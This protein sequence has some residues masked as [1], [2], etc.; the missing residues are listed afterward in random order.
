MLMFLVIGAI[1]LIMLLV[2]GHGDHDGAVDHDVSVGHD[3][4]VGGHD[5]G[6]AGSFPPILS[7]FNIS[8]FMM[9]FGAVGAGMRYFNLSAP[10]SALGG[11]GGGIVLGGIAFYCLGLFYRQQADSTMTTARIVGSVGTVTVP[12]PPNGSGKAQFTV[13][14]E[15]VELIVR[16]KAGES[17][18]T[19]S[20]VRVLTEAGG[21]YLVE[22]A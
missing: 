8:W 2:S 19:G 10:V 5:A 21:M 15:G 11:L 7:M 4:D 14:R 18:A 16:S 3:G 17:L 20:Q 22:K 1:G 9:G 6:D 13:G 12:A